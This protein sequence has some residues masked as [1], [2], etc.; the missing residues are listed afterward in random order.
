VTLSV[1][2]QAKAVYET[3]RASL[4]AEHL[5]GFVAIEPV[6][7]SHFIGK[8]FVEAAMAAREAMPDRRS[9]VMRVGRDAAFHI[10]AST[11]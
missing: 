3:L 4:E 9:F 6:S 5:D 2:E 8:T 10:G 1:A 7:K 11:S